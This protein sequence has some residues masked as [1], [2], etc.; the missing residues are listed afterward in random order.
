MQSHKG[1]IGM[2]DEKRI[3]EILHCADDETAAEISEMTD[4]AD[5][6]T[7]DK[8]YG[9]LCSRLAAKNGSA[10]EAAETF[11][12]TVTRKPSW[13]RTAIATAACLVI[14]GGLTGGAVMLH[15][16]A[17]SLK[18]PGTEEGTTQDLKVQKEIEITD[19]VDRT[20]TENLAVAQ[21]LE[22]I[23]EDDANRYYFGSLY[24]QY[25]I[26]H[27][28]DGSQ[29]DVKTALHS[30][31]ATLADLDR[32]GIGYYT[33]PKETTAHEE[34][35]PRTTPPTESME[36]TE[37]STAKAEASTE[38]TVSIVSDTTQTTTSTAGTTD[39]SPT[40][41]TTYQ[42]AS[43]PL[44]STTV[45][46]TTQVIA[47]ESL[48]SCKVTVVNI[49][50]RTKTEPIAVPDALEEIYYD[51]TYRYY[52]SG[53]YSQYVIVTYSDGTQ[54]DVKSALQSGRA[55]IADLDRFDIFYW[56]ESNNGFA[57]SLTPEQESALA[58]LRKKGDSWVGEFTRQEK[59][60]LGE[61][62]ANAKRMTFEQAND[63]IGNGKNLEDVIN[64]FNDV[65]GC[66]DFVGGSGVTRMEYWLDD[67][68][69]EQ[70]L[71]FLEQ[72]DIYHVVGSTSE[73]LFAEVDG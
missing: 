59:I 72:V 53:I 5:A 4:A 1:G 28:S 23:Y 20:K 14:A 47:T 58:E 42:I 67:E 38:T 22:Q 41:T 11:A 36:S 37:T 35:Q 13:M 66:P 64:Q 44:Q 48:P 34:T 62:P 56:K 16:S 18:T 24:S 9:M 15:R 30:G 26:V 73:L 69:Y 52:L 3:E 43:D 51:G 12:V 60:I 7:K 68:G 61:L 10:D 21:A 32:F 49:V 2:K 40:N 8:I 25:V 46:S 54:E 71:V 70:I 31:R 63:I 29:E 33:E 55:T 39:T 57:P 45:T 19:I 6:Q 50:D 27:Y 17:S 65:H